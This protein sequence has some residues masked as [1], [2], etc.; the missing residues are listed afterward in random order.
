VF[1]MGKRLLSL[2]LHGCASL[3]K[4]IVLW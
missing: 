4:L 1:F 3:W 2:L